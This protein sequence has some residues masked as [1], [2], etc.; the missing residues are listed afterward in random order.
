MRVRLI[1]TLL[2]AVFLPL[3]VTA[4]VAQLAVKATSRCLTTSCR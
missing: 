1:P 3:N 4:A 2:G